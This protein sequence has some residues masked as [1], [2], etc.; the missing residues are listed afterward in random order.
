MAVWVQLSK[1]Y[2][3]LQK[4]EWPFGYSFQ[5]FVFRCKKT[6]GRLGTGFKIL[7]FVVKNEWRFGCN[8]KIFYFPVKN[9]W[10]F[11][12]T[13]SFCNKFRINSKGSYLNINNFAFIFHYQTV[14]VFKIMIFYSNLVSL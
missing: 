7:H 6:N 5:N 1:F 3:S 14:S 12:Y 9:H 8:C 13:H 10:P 4:H 11:G 2:T